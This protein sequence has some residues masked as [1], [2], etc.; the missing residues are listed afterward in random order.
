MSGLCGTNQVRQLMPII[1]A[2]QYKT[3]L[4]SPSKPSVSE[5]RPMLAHQLPLAPIQ[6]VGVYPNRQEL[7]DLL[8]SFQA[9]ICFLDVTTSRKEAFEVIADLHA[10]LPALPI[11]VLLANNDPD[12]VLQCLR[13]GATD[14]LI[15]PFTT[16][17][18]DG[19]IEKIARLLPAPGTQSSGAGK[20]IS[21]IPA[22]GASGATTIAC[23]LAFQFKRLGVKKT[24][25]GDMDPLTGTVPFALKLK[26]AY[27]FLDVLQRQ[28]T[29]DA[30]LWK[31]MVTQS[32]GIEVMLPPEAFV[33]PIADL[34]SA[35]PILEY[36]R[37]IYDAVV[38]DCGG[39]YGEWNLSLARHCDELLLVTTTDLLSLE[40]AQ[41]AMIHFDR[42]RID[43]AK[44][45]LIVNCA[46]KGSGLNLQ[47]ISKVFQCEIFQTIP[48]DSEA[49]NKSL[50]EGKP[51]AANTTIGKS[52][53]IL[54]DKL[55]NHK[56]TSKPKSA[57]KGGLFSSIFSR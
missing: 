27:S 40:A 37:D 7:V 42:N 34:Q 10:L 26:S 46:T 38:L 55:M 23:S 13:Q 39:P 35:A 57:A 15:R 6:D 8:R 49:V 4:I 32:N 17:Q 18:L 41:R 29:L 12:L 5:L 3:L 56:E 2:R 9:S 45:R 21:V 24:L 25:L 53:A 44:V 33:D 28:G 50:M 52:F 16:E 43:T 30:D 1:D 47:N 14:F 31:Q 51:I 36:A 48:A 11:V 19:C 22:K 54:A 20:I